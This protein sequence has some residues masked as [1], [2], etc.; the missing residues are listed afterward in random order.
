MKKLFFKL[1]KKYSRREKGRLDILSILADNVGY[2]YNEQTNFGNV[3]NFNI[4][5]IMSNKLIKKLVKNNDIESLKI[6]KRGLNK[7]FDEAIE[8]IKKET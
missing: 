6:I 5:F 8:F 7:S 4:E 2:E 3:Y 1:L